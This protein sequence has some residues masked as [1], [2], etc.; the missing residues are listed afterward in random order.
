M[1]GVIAEIDTLRY[2]PAGIP[3][4]KFRLEHH[5]WQAE[6]GVDREV[7]VAMSVIALGD[8]ALMAAKCKAGQA[9]V[10]KGFLSQRSLKSDYPVLH[11]NQIKLLEE[12][13]HGTST[14]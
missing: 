2:T 9:V 8:P 6:V 14:S 13:D 7:T 3:H 10:V 11:I 1:D 4:M 5:S 12:K